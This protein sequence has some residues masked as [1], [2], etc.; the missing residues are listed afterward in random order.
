MHAV[1][2]LAC[3]TTESPLQPVLQRAMLAW[4]AAW[5]VVNRER[6]VHDIRIPARRQG[7]QVSEWKAGRRIR[8][9]ERCG[10]RIVPVT[11]AR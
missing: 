10:G 9:S 6:K 2:R 7:W 3:N 8:R 5:F 4:L 11:T 1:Q